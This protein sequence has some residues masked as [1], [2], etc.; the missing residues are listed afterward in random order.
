MICQ[1]CKKRKAV[2]IIEKILHCGECGLKKYGIN[3]SNGRNVSS[4]RSN[5]TDDGTY[6]II[7][8]R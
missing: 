2:I 3:N 6:K 8:Y 1:K 5:K 4:S 7:Q